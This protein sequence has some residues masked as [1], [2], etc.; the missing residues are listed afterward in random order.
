MPTSTTNDRHDLDRALKLE[1][2]KEALARKDSGFCEGGDN[3]QRGDIGRMLTDGDIDY[4]HQA[5]LDKD[6]QILEQMHL[7]DS[8]SEDR[9]DLTSPPTSPRP[10]QQQ[11]VSPATRLPYEIICQIIGF[12]NPKDQSTLWGCSGISRLWYSAAIPL[13]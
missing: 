12:I 2:R 9:L 11:E 4:L 7:S 1:E 8:L 13:L 5:M 3:Y 10:S 6:L